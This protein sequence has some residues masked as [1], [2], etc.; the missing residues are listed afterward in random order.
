M[1]INNIQWNINMFFSSM[2]CHM[3]FE[4]CFAAREWGFRKKILLQQFGEK[5]RNL[6]QTPCRKKTLKIVP[7]NY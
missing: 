3:C 2:N 6:I 4:F 7:Y 1:I 5:N